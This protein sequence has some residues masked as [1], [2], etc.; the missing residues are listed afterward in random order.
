MRLWP[1]AVPGDHVRYNPTANKRGSRLRG[2][3]SDIEF[4]A[5]CERGYF[6]SVPLNVPL[7]FFAI[8]S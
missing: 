8:H 5:G 3:P 4:A 2:A 1:K 6:L 7:L